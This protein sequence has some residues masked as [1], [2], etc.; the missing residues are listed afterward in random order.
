MDRLVLF[1]SGVIPTAISA[2]PDHSITGG[3]PYLTAATFT[4]PDVVTPPVTTAPGRKATEKAIGMDE[5]M[6]ITSA[7]AEA[8]GT[9]ATE[10]ASRQQKRG[11]PAAALF[12]FCRRQAMLLK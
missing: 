12:R 2:M 5:S 3:T 10:E 7:T 4:G 9:T 1:P 6:G 8:M 11:G